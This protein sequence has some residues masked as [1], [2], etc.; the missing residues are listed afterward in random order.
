MRS[1]VRRAVWVWLPGV[2]ALSRQGQ[3]QTQAPT[4]TAGVLVY[5][6]YGMQLH[7]DSV[8]G[9]HLNAFD[10]TRAYIN[11]VG[12]FTDGVTVRVTPDVYRVTDGSLGFRLKYAYAAWT[13]EKSPITAKFGLMHTPW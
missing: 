13:P 6:Q 8:T 10:I 12:K 1:V 11:V 3:A 2:I 4:M 9:R 7:T 5:S